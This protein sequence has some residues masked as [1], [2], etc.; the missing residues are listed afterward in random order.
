MFNECNVC[1]QICLGGK[2]ETNQSSRKK[3]LGMGLKKKTTV[4]QLGNGGTKLEAIPSLK[5]YEDKGRRKQKTAK[6]AW[7]QA[8]ECVSP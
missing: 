6:Y 2:S 8:M 3:L 7:K 4:H 1:H 5:N